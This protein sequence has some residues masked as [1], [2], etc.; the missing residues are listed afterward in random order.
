MHGIR[1]IIKIW[2]STFLSIPVIYVILL[3]I[4]SGLH[5][6]TAIETT[7]I[8]Y[9]VP[10][11]FLMSVWVTLGLFAT[12]QLSADSAA[13]RRNL[14]ITGL[15]A[16]FAALIMIN[17][18]SALQNYGGGYLL[19]FAYAVS[20]ILF[21]WLY[22]LNLYIV[23]LKTTTQPIK[24][25]I[26]YGL[27]VWLFTFL[28]STP[29][30]VLIW[31]LTKDYKSNSLAKTIQDILERYN[32]QLSLSIAFFITVTIVTLIVINQNVTEN[33]KK[34]I[35]FLF[36]FP[37]T[38]P[39]LFYY[40]LFGGGIYTNSLPELLRLIFPS[41]IVSAFSIWLTDIIPGIKSKD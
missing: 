8:T 33:Q 24:D 1:Y 39:V 13:V 9:V 41:I 20:T 37:L 31:I 28:L 17:S 5:V 12:I 7:L 10:Y 11:A 34:A 36:G 6:P 30:S 2:L 21:I 16:P 29:V 27:S 26:I 14:R 32:F 25:A 19:A 22:P 3:T 18:I 38:F 4:S 35:I 40:L 15:L 23:K